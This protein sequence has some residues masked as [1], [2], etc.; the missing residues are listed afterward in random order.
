MLGGEGGDQGTKLPGGVNN[1]LG[2][3]NISVFF[4]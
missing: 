4:Y 3:L 2:N 1:V